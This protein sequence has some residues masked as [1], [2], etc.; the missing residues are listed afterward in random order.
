MPLADVYG[1]L[2]I[3]ALGHS[4][5]QTGM[6][7]AAKSG[8]QRVAV[9]ANIGAGRQFKLAGRAFEK[10]RRVAVGAN[11]ILIAHQLAATAAKR[12]TALWAKA[13]LDV[14]RRLANGALAGVVFFRV[15][16]GSG[17]NGRFL[18]LIIFQ[19]FTTVRADYR[20]RINLL[21]AKGTVNGKF[22]ATAAAK[23]IIGVDGG[24]A[25]RAKLLF[26]FR[27]DVSVVG[28]DGVAGRT[29]S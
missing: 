12:R 22:R 20:L 13:I 14:E 6:A 7:A 5:Q 27:A 23:S 21:I 19:Q 26:T 17:G 28:N 11:V 24:V 29:T 15:G 9:G 10:Q 3:R 4:R 25:G 2:T 1:R 18:C 8:K 16:V